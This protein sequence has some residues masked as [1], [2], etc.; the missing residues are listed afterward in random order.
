MKK[1]F[2]FIVASMFLS[3][4]IQAQVNTDSVRLDADTLLLGVGDIINLTA[5]VYPS[6]A[7]DQ[8]VTW[9]IIEG[10]PS[11]INT[12]PSANILEIEALSVGTVKVEVNTD[13]GNFKDTCVV[14]VINPLDGISLNSDDTL[15]VYLAR[16]TVLIA[17]IS[18]EDAT[19]RSIVWT[20]SDSAV[21]DIVSIVD[22][23][24][25]YLKTLSNGHATI[26][27]SVFDGYD[28]DGFVDS[29]VIVVDYAPVESISLNKDSVDMFLG[30]DTTLIATL[31]P[32]SGINREVN[33]RTLDPSIVTMLSSGRDTVYR[34]HARGLGEAKIVAISIGTPTIT[35]TCVVTVHGILAEDMT[36]NENALVMAINTDS[37]LIAR[38]FPSN[39]TNDSIEWT[40]SDS[41]IVDIL[42]TPADMNDTICHIS[43]LRSGTAE[44]TARTFDGDFIDICIVEVIVPVDSI[45]LQAPDSITLDIG[46]T[47]ELKAIVYPDSATYDTVIWEISDPLL[48]DTLFTAYDTI[49]EITAIKAG[50]TIVYVLS[51]DSVR[52]DSCVVTINPIPVTGIT[53]SN[54]S[55]DLPWSEVFTL[56]ATLAPPEASDQTA[57]WTSSDSAIVD[58]ITTGND[59]LCDIK[60]L[61]YG[62]AIIYVVTNDGDFKDSCV[63]SVV[64]NITGLILINDSMTIY[65]DN[66]VNTFFYSME[67]F[68]TPV[69]PEIPEIVWT[70]SDPSVVDISPMSHDSIVQLVPMSIGTATIYAKTLYGGFE[71]SCVVTVKEQYVVLESDTV[72]ANVK[73]VIEVLLILPDKALLSS[74]FDLSLPRAFGLTRDGGTYKSALS[75]DCKDLYDLSIARVEDSIY[76]FN[77]IP[78]KSTLS[79]TDL[80]SGSLLKLMDIYYTIYEN[81]SVIDSENFMAKLTNVILT[82]DDNLVLEDDRVDVVIKSYKDPT[83]N[84]VIGRPAGYSFMSDNRL[85]VNTD[86]A[87]TIS[88]FALNGTLLFTGDKQEGQAL[89]NLKT[90][91]QLLIV[92]GSSG[93]TEK[94][95]NR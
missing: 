95:V 2:L 91:E 82:F 13:D 47:F 48:I 19:E 52:Q 49:C 33:W 41:T 94:V 50:E 38:L 78:A 53:I 62:E 76:H 14:H 22:D 9:D 31:T 15:Y 69:Q 83:G 51:A 18:P 66:D 73:G 5:T 3:M 87:E 55:L 46:D 43:A 58:I 25:C 67:A 32:S 17:T 44:I 57:V 4:T 85:V 37:T 60:A 20:S 12:T 1:A 56:T 80:P 71:D 10:D 45:V 42:S 81:I 24:I 23:S 30:S 36:L 88:V 89:F 27:A 54:D 64:P 77:I 68:I 11:I 63:V 92:T 90:P 79:R 8:G 74:S 72:T 26:Y 86:K 70:S 35:D 7:D 59:L 16:D 40:S 93:W 29:C 21:V 28:I 84:I 34:I 65:L 75:D 39:T 61:S 6:D